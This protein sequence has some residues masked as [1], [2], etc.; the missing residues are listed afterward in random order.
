MAPLPTQFTVDRSIP[1]SATNFWSIQAAVTAASAGTTITVANGVYNE[2]VTISTSGITLKAES[3]RGVIINGSATPTPPSSDLGT[4]VLTNG[5]NDVTIGGTGHGFII[6]GYDGPNPGIETAAV[7]LQGD[8]SNLVIQDNEIVANGDAG[9]QGEWSAVLTGLLIDGNTFSGQTFVGTIP[10]GEGFGGQF[11]DAN[12]PRQLVVLGGNGQNA[13]NITFT[14]NIVSGT[15]GGTNANGNAQGNSLVTIDAEDSLISGNSFTGFT[16]RFG[17]QL[18]VREG[19]DTVT[20]NDFSSDAGGNVGLITD[21]SPGEV[22]G[23]ISNLYD[24]GSGDDMILAVAGNDTVDGGLGTDTL[25]MANAGTA[26]SF[27]DLMTGTAFSTAT[28]IDSLLNIENVSGSAG[29]DG[30]FGNVGAN[31][32]VATAGA[33]VIDG[34]GGVDTFDASTAT[35][36]IT[37]NLSTGAVTGAFTA[38]LTSIESIRTGNGNDTVTG[39]SADNLIESGGG[40]DRIIGSGGNDTI[41]AGGGT[42]VVVLSG[43]RGDWTI[44]WNGTTATA[45]NGTDSVTIT[46]AGRLSFADK[47]VILVSASG[48]FTSIQAGVN[49]ADGGDEVLVAD[50]TYAGD[51][52]VTDKAITIAAAGSG[53]T[54]QGQISVSDAMETGD[55]MRFIGLNI[56]ATGRFYGVLVQSS[57]IDG[58]GVNAGAVEIIGGSI[59]NAGSQGLFYSH[60]SNGSSPTNLNTIGSF[61]FDGVVFENNGFYYTGARGQ[62]HV[63]LFGFNGNLTVRDSTFTGPATDQGDAA[64]RGGTISTSGATVNPDKAISV[65]G[66]RTGT[67]GVG[68]Y[69]D[70]GVLIIDN[71][72]ITGFYGSDVVSFYNIQSFASNSI[73]GL[74]IDASAR[75]TLVNFDGVSGLVDLSTGVDGTNSLNGQISQLQGLSA[76]DTFTGTDGSDF[77]NGRGGADDLSGGDGNDLFGYSAAAEFATGEQVDGG[78]GTDTLLFGSAAAETLVLSVDVTSI[79]NV[80][81][82]TGST[83]LGVDASAVG[84]AL[85]IMGNAGANTI[86]ATDFADTVSAGNGNDTVTGGEGNDSIDGGAGT[87]TVVVAGTA[88]FSA[89]GGVWT[90]TTSGDGADSLQNVEIVDDGG[91]GK[92]ILVGQGGIATIQEAL[93]LAGDGDTILI[94]EGTYSGKFTIT[95]NNLTIKGIGDPAN[96][97]IAGSFEA[98]NGITGSVKEFFETATSYNNSAGAGITIAASGVSLQNLTIDSFYVGV[99]LGNGISNVTLTDVDITDTEVGIRKG[100]AAT[101]TNITINGGTISDS[102]QGISFFKAVGAAGRVNGLVIDGTT[103]DGLGEKGIYLETGDNVSILDIVMNDVGQFGRGPAFGSSAQVGEFGAGIDINLKYDN[104]TPYSGIIIDG[105]T[106]TDVGLS[107]GPDTVLQDFGAAIAIKARN[108]ASSYNTNPAYYTGALIVQNGSIIGTSTAIRVGEPGKTIAGPAVTVTNVTVDGATVGEL[109][110]VTT[111]IATVV[112]TSASEVWHTVSTT[113]GQV[114]ISGGDGADTIYGGV[115]GDTLIG[116]TGD[117]VLVGGTGADVLNGNSGFDTASYAASD[118]A[119]SV[120]LQ[121]GVASGGHATGDVLALIEYLIG[122]DYG[123]TLNGSV[124][125]NILFGGGGNDVMNGRAGSDVLW[126]GE[127]SDNLVGGDGV[128]FLRGGAGADTLTGGAAVDTADYTDSDAAVTVT[129]GNSTGS[130]GHAQGDTLI[131]IE[132]L[133]GADGFGDILNGN[134]GV[135]RIEGLGGNDTILAGAGSDVVLGGLGQDEITLGTGAD[136]VA[137]ASSTE[138]GDTVT[139]FNVAADTFQFAAAGFAGLVAGS[140]LGVTG[141]FV[142]NASGTADGAMAQVVYDNDDGL[143]FWDADGTGSGSAVLIATLSNLA[144][145][146]AADFLIV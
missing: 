96:I 129:A 51:V 38:S 108:D 93:L 41:H 100:T 119:V 61:V 82:A 47:D 111:S 5:V 89:S 28:G 40:N 110:N 59:S 109:D 131:S 17:G 35:G 134:A 72:D 23:P 64:F 145:L 90:V 84:N 92:I 60:P 8:H 117:D 136:R 138:G 123:D 44:T 78:A 137:Y 34:R 86:I 62:G 11:T 7:Y 12:V 33:D 18:R 10:G 77:L 116:G 83:G 75:W 143:L 37:A 42:D 32:F 45:T 132:N 4:V 99:E 118:A 27:V 19:G 103:F 85:S 39:S 6:N 106:F 102:Y 68:G 26:G 141:Q 76:D 67:P 144:G 65:S 130:G 91:T 79:E 140:S 125:S 71:V 49:A 63:N 16:N 25:L 57:A 66:V 128:D 1:E 43:N 31:T 124:G 112:M 142:S 73:T 120:D 14:N 95:Q 21:F 74:D 126:G 105:F 58:P 87:D 115:N 113:T 135:N 3:D 54:V 30:L 50:G 70:A 127:G 81:L 94:G 46:G 98:D 9:L 55:V 88:T 122:S 36:A 69:I 24:Y 104:G 114:R 146:T 20:G 107:A 80:T 52:T 29:A 101:V 121:V 15:A 97:V 139:D 13:S 48:E 53:V 133:R 22:P 56:D 2:N